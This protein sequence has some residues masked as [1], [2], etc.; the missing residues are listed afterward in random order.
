MSLSDTRDQR[1]VNRPSPAAA[2]I[3]PGGVGEASGSWTIRTE[4]TTGD[5]SP[6]ASG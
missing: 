6:R 1:I 4:E 3:E 2:E 5:P